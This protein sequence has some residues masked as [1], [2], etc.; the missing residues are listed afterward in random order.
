MGVETAKQETQDQK[1]QKPRHTGRVGEHEGRAMPV[2]TSVIS[3]HVSRV[4]CEGCEYSGLYLAY[5]RG[6]K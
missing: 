3:T 1:D 6:N 5:L 2:T 4:L